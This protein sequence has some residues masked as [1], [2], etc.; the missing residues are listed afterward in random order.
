[1][2][3]R[4][5]LASKSSTYVFLR[6]I[7]LYVLRCVNLYVLRCVNSYVLRFSGVNTCMFSGV[8]TCMFSNVYTCMFWLPH[9]KGGC[10]EG[11]EGV[12]VPLC[13]NTSKL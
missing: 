7:Y 4:Y 5:I 6:C 1:M 12:F 13:A 3:V 2:N 8:T 9:M 11:G 10:G